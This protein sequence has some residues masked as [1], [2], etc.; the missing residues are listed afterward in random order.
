MSRSI[1]DLI[2][3]MQE[4]AAMAVKAMNEDKEL[5]ALGTDGV[6]IS[7][8]RRTL[9][10]QMAY[11]SRGRMEPSD[12]Q[13]MYKAAGLY[14]IGTAEAKSKNTWTLQ[15]KHIEG[16]AID[17]VPLINER[18]VWTC[19]PGFDKAKFNRILD[20]IGEIGK[21]HGLIWGGDWD[22]KDYPHFEMDED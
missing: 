9:A 6:F 21:E 22:V 8:T 10:V 1:K 7:E 4:R 18:A 14:D 17:I 13:K 5:K 2:P 19:P 20:R 15:S 11:Y 16:K 12:T 3:A